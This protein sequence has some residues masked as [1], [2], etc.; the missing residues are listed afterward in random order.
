MSGV[1]EAVDSH[2]TFYFDANLE[3]FREHEPQIA[4]VMLSA[5]ETHARHGSDG[6]SPLPHN[7]E[8]HPFQRADC[9]AALGKVAT[10]KEMV[11]LAPLVYPKFEE[12]V[13]RLVDERNDMLSAAAEVLE[14][15]GDITIATDHRQIIGVAV[16]HCALMSALYES[17]HINHG[18][19]DTEIIVSEML[20]YTQ[21]LGTPAVA[22][23]QDIFSTT[24]FVVPAANKKNKDQ[25]P[26][27][28][29]NSANQASIQ[30]RHLSSDKPRVTAVAPSGTGDVYSPTRIFGKN[31]RKKGY[32]MAPPSN[33]T[34]EEYFINKHVLPMGIDIQEDK[35]VYLGRLRRASEVSLP[36][37]V[38][39]MMNEI[40]EGMS[41]VSSKKSFFVPDLDQF[42]R[43]KENVQRYRKGIS[44]NSWE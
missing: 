32:Y 23:L 36:A 42:R 39:V 19:V 38:Y 22:L 41:K 16:G 7:T 17:G 4:K 9:V 29:A 10:K 20:K 25:L 8:A 27:G 12:L 34:I 37:D 44:V 14:Q 33:G 35:A 15:G 18:D 5:V 6:F 3:S 43:I 31:K 11:D 26:E 30:H 40:A 13:D 21:I 1:T 2:R 28:F 24:R